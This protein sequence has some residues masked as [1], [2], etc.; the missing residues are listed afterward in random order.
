MVAVG[1]CSSAITI[2]LVSLLF[3]A[4]SAES[5]S[6]S[7]NSIN[8]VFDVSCFDLLVGLLPT[9]VMLPLAPVPTTAELFAR[10][11]SPSRSENCGGPVVVS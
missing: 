2:F 9:S 6:A 8:S 1:P 10:R 3:S 7:I 11:L 4:F 5:Y